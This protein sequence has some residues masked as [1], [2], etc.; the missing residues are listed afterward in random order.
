M[1]SGEASAQDGSQGRI[2]L[3]A[4]DPPHRRSTRIPATA[5]HAVAVLLPE[6]RPQPV[7]YLVAVGATAL[8]LAATLPAASLLQRAI[9]VLFWPAVIGSAWF[10]GLGPA[11][12]ASALSVLAVDYYLIGPPGKIALA[13]PEDLVPL[14]AFLFASTAVSMLTTAAR[15]AGRCAAMAAAQN[16]DLAHELE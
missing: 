6:E 9:F 15:T 10:G 11:I 16:A 1:T 12:L 7:R 2:E 4:N 14:A 8:A 3:Q 13:T 5:S